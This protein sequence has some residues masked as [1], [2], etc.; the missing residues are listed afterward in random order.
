MQMSERQPSGEIR[1]V[2]GLGPAI[3]AAVTT[4][5]LHG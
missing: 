5:P 2:N 4:L 3:Q 1:D